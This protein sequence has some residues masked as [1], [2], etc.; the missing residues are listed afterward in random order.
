MGGGERFEV[1]TF[2]QEIMARTALGEARGESDVG[3][4]AVMW[5][6]INR[7]TAKKWFSALSI[8]GTFLLPLQFS[9]WNPEDPNRK[10]IADVTSDIS[11]FEDCLAWAD[12]VIKGTI[13]DPTLGATHYK[14]VGSDASWAE[15]KTPVVTIGNHEFYKNID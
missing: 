6:G 1:T 13:P 3:M 15:G 14:R 4:Q 10:Y 11:L 9:C 2:D 8:A 7:F 12:A 5:V